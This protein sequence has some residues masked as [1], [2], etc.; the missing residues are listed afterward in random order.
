MNATAAAALVRHPFPTLE[1]VMAYR[2]PDVVARFLKSWNL[3]QE[4]AEAIFD[5]LK[6][7]LWVSAMSKKDE[8]AGEL[9]VQMAILNSMILV[10]E[11][12]HAF[13][14]FTK[15]YTQFCVEHFGFYIHHG[16]TTQA[17]NEEAIAA[18]HADPAAFEA[19]VTAEFEAQFS[20]IY[21]KLGPEVLSRWYSEWTDN[22]TQSYLDGIALPFRL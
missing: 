3:P 16:P 22:V 20:Y 21:D 13:I 12:W 10:D 19:Q 2:H 8:L 17:Q 4:E 18:M 1:E 6:R 15:D 11:M 5:D 7:W 14:L 9:V